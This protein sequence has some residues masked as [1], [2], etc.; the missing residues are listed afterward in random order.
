[1]RNTAVQDD[2][3]FNRQRADALMRRYRLDAIIASTPENVLYA[4]GFGSLGPFVMRDMECFALWPAESKNAALVI[5]KVEIEFTVDGPPCIEDIVS[6]GSSTTVVPADPSKLV[7]YERALYELLLAHAET[8]STPAE[9][10]VTI[11][12]ERGLETARLAL[13]E[14]GISRRT[15][16]ALREALPRAEIVEAF[17]IW[18]E[19]RAV[20]TAEEIRRL[21]EVTRINEEALSSVYASVGEGVD[22]RSLYDL[23]VTNVTKLGGRF[24]YWYSGV[25]TQSCSSWLSSSYRAKSSDLVRIDG[26]CTWEYYWS[27]TGR[28]LILD[29]PDAKKRAYYEAIRAGVEAGLAMV[30]PGV[31]ASDIFERIVETTRKEGIHHYYRFHCGHGIGLE[32]Y[33]MPVIQPAKG[34]DASLPEQEDVLLEQNMVL[35]IEAPYYE[36]GFGGLQLEET[37]LVTDRGHECLTKWDRDMMIC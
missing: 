32:M 20:K 24:G 29:R 18:R 23:Y 1:M 5:P 37:I 21:R 11:L 27:D 31:K 4:S 36:L 7:G 13:D 25:G 9:A 19:I 17:H 35:N 16:G 8:S 22:G 2:M 33:E 12:R 14:R 34:G 3:I 30:R 15:A 26:T 28:T 6:Y 10:L